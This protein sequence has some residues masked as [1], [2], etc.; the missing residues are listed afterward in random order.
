MTFLFSRRRFSVVLFLIFA[1]STAA[2]AQPTTGGPGADFS[3]RQVTWTD[4]ENNPVAPFS[5]YGV[6][7]VTTIEPQL[8]QVLWVNASINGEWVLQNAP[9]I[10]I[11]GEGTQQSY[12]YDLPLPILPGFP[13]PELPIQVE[14][15]PFELVGPPVTPPLMLPVQET[16]YY[17]GGVARD[18]QPLLP[19]IPTAPAQIISL[20]FLPVWETAHR[21]GVPGVSEEKNHCAPGAWARSIAWMNDEYCFELPDDCDEAQELYESLATE[22]GTTEAD[23]TSTEPANDKDGLEEVVADKDLGDKVTVVHRTDLSDPAPTPSDLF[24]ALARGCDV[25]SYVGWLNAAGDRVNGHAVTVVGAI[26]CGTTIRIFYRDDVEGDDDQGDG[27]ADDGV[28]TKTFEAGGPT[29]YRLAGLPNNQWEGFMALCP[30]LETVLNSI[31]KDVL[32]SVSLTP[33]ATPG[34]PTDPVVTTLLDL[35]YRIRDNACRLTL[36]A[37]DVT[38]ANPDAVALAFCLKEQ[39][40]ELVLLAQFLSEDP[41]LDTIDAMLALLDSMQSKGEEFEAITTP[42]G[43]PEFVRGDCNGDGSV[44][45]A[46]AIG[47]LNLLFAGGSITCADACDTNDDGSINIAD[48][49]ALLNTLF[50]GGTIPGPSTCGPDSTPDGLDCDVY[51]PCP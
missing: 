15:T 12:F 20:P 2:L 4:A 42:T 10:E 48:A 43:E 18:G 49:I 11:D 28:K 16:F 24:D 5:D 23:G 45:I 26:R 8:G 39:A 40:I 7:Q 31:I 38:P 34:D 37:Q 50:G 21:A 1:M 17:P 36:H 46:D 14:I 47:L 41:A 22:M 44:N 51:A 27:D 29:G 6:L 32:D 25:V 30:T 13:I 3:I 33:S 9:L 19:V 35:A